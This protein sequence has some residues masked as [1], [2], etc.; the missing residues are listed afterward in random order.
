MDFLTMA[1]AI[2]LPGILVTAA[3]GFMVRRVE[4]KLDKEER[5]R[6][7]REEARKKHEAYIVS[8]LTATAALG[9]ANAIA[10]KNGKCNGET[11]AALEYLEQVKHDHREFL[12]YQGLDHIF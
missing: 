9:K 11:K 6:H 10:L 12:N 4:T 5:T 1:A 8:M 3:V 2:G 7:E